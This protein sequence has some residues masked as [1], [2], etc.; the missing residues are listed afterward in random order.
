MTTTQ[1]MRS[2]AARG[3]SIPTDTGLSPAELAQGC[4]DLAIILDA[5][6]AR[7]DQKFAVTGLADTVLHSLLEKPEM[8]RYMRNTFGADAVPNHD[9]DAWG[10]EEYATAWINTRRAFARHGIELEADPAATRTDGRQAELCFMTVSR[11]D[12]RHAEL[13]FL[14]VG[15]TDGRHAELCFLS[16]GRTVN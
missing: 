15:R 16:V 5:M 8:T 4:T 12:G 1:M 9:P 2:I 3:L 10:T 7:P 14:S 11:N 13:C 6:E